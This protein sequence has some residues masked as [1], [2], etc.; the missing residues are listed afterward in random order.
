M[1]SG[2][3]SNSGQTLRVST[4]CRLAVS[5]DPSH[6]CPEMQRWSLRPVFQVSCIARGFATTT[7]VMARTYKVKRPGLRQYLVRRTDRWHRT[8]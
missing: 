6:A 7:A 2:W 1:L 5:Q 3:H 4:H 8:P